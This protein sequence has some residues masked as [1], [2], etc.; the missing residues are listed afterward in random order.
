MPK[1]ATEKKTSK[2]ITTPQ[3]I[4]VVT[5]KNAFGWMLSLF[6]VCGCMF[7]IGVLVG[8][9]QAPV[10]FDTQE[11]EQDL[12][13][14]KISV[15]A[16]QEQ[17]LESIE[18]IDILDFLKEKGKTIQG[19]KQ[20]IPPLLSP[21]YGKNPPAPDTRPVAGEPSL[22]EGA[23][24]QRVAAMTVKT[25]ATAA[26]QSGPAETAATAN[27]ADMDVISGEGAAMETLESP[28]TPDTE[29][30][31]GIDVEQT[32]VYGAIETVAGQARGSETIET[33]A[34]QTPGSE[35]IQ[36][37]LEKPAPATDDM[38]AVKTPATTKPSAMTSLSGPVAEDAYTPI[39]SPASL[40]REP[41]AV[42]SP[43]VVASMPAPTDL[44]GPA[45]QYAIQVASLR[46]LD[47][48]NDVRD[49]FRARGYPAYCQSSEVRGVIWHR[50]RIGP[51]PDRHT[52]DQDCMR[53]KEVGVD[54]LVFVL[55]R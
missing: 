3:P 21:K 5:G 28:E 14:L 49:K 7:V 55:E 52:A 29:A 23:G 19:Y 9:G 22:P 2:K 8:R 34:G 24:E 53:L 38:I 4:I 6:V 44:A 15:L 10:H 50:V 42:L 51:Y 43:G 48:A 31:T 16:K 13:N 17:I 12:K 41:A 18:H 47:K 39:Q 40:D 1:P 32:P 20:Y 45:L 27:M 30:I 36:E 11:W 26:D 37:D 54:A 35:A 25:P 33:F 46:E